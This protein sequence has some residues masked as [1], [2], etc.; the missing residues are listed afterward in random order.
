MLAVI[1]MLPTDDLNR[2]DPPE[3]GQ[4]E[5]L[6]LILLIGLV[7]IVGVGMLLVA[8]TSMDRVE[9]QIEFEQ[10]KLAVN[11]FNSQLH[12]EVSQNGGQT[13]DFA[14][15]QEGAKV[16]PGVGDITVKIDGDRSCTILDESMGAVRYERDGKE[17]AAQGGG[18]WEH[19]G[20]TSQMVSAPNIDYRGEDGRETLSLPITVLNGDS[21]TA[22]RLS[23]KNNETV[24]KY[25]LSTAGCGEDPLEDGEVVITIESKYAEGWGQF[26]EE[27]VRATVSYPDKRTV[28]A[29]LEGPIT[30][31]QVEGPIVSN[32][33]SVGVSNN[34]K[35]DSYDSSVGPY[36]SPGNDNAPVIVEGDFSPSNNIEIGGNVRAGG[37][38]YISNN[39]DINGET[40]VG[41]NS[42][43]S[44]N[45]TFTGDYSTSGRMTTWGG[46]FH[47]DVIVGGDADLGN[48]EVNGDVHVQGDV[49]GLRNAEIEGDVIA[50]GSVSTDGATIE[51]DVYEHGTRTPREPIDPNINTPEP[52]DDK[53]KTKR[54]EFASSN[55]NDETTAV[56]GNELT[57]CS[58][59]C[60][61][62]SGT[63]YLNEINLHNKNVELNTSNGPIELYVDDGI[64]LSGDSEI[65]VT[66]NTGVEAHLNGDLSLSNDARVT[67][68]GDRSPLF[69][70][71][72]HS[73]HSAAFSNKA[74]FTGIVYGP[75][76][77]SGT[78][79]DIA[80]SNQVEIFG[81]LVG[82]IDGTSNKNEIHFDEALTE[83]HELNDDN[84]VSQ[85]SY[86][87][88][89]V[90]SVD[91]DSN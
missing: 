86:L 63:Y 41:E 55:D 13:I 34:G 28:I 73:D 45:P 2:D 90:R 9:K 26:F 19:D 82:N 56:T 17:V 60:T 7:A 43:I 54:T 35:I 16:D 50:G 33:A 53:I 29:T 32:A 88:V 25:P 22:N 66:G 12:T 27:Q 72:I 79:A 62:E 6:G 36:S 1:N 20:T 61:L 3:Q 30:F 59:S 67:V 83:P 91:I 64:S 85:V 89:R 58:P 46:T 11:E 5:L 39:I 49:E 51:G 57:N 47:Q 74:S 80:I 81:A 52:V 75:A 38:A 8:G 76:P 65:K 84:D 40:R 4:A 44:N 48:A 21:Q 15:D 78:G 42:D 31:G 10:A 37:N 68:P 24:R 18:V 14:F 70:L 23:F 71:N 87:D 69:W 77:T